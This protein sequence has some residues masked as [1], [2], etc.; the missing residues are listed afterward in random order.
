VRITTDG[1]EPS[2]QELISLGLRQE[3]L[4]KAILIFRDEEVVG[5]NPATP[6]VEQQVNG[7]FSSL[8]NGCWHACARAMPAELTA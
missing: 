3:S 1:G 4:R 5:S 7:R 6:T 8:E 2:D